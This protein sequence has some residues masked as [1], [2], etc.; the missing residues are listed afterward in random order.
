MQ[1]V[2]FLYYKSQ[3]CFLYRNMGDSLNYLSS[4]LYILWSENLI[5][6]IIFYNISNLYLYL[7]KHKK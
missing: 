3:I 2:I 4:L 5:N 1:R 6:L 7:N